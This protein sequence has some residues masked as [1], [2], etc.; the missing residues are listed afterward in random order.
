[1]EIENRLTH[2]ERDHA[3]TKAVVAT[4]DQ[5]IAATERAIADLKGDIQ[6]GFSTVNSSIQNLTTT[7]LKAWP[8]EAVEALESARQETIRLSSTKGMM[9]GAA[10]SLLGVVAVLIG[11]AL[12]HGG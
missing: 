7:A 6:T 2:L 8:P 1:M 9:I 10:V 5:R 11:L 12:R 3:N 4:L